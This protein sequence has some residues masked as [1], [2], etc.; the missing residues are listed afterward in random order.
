MFSYR[1]VSVCYKLLLHIY[2]F[3][4]IFIYSLCVYVCIC[5]YIHLFIYLYV[6][7]IKLVILALGIFDSK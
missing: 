2:M 6:A 7:G 4:H 5:A 1:N 3:T